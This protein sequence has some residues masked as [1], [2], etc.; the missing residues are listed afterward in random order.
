MPVS[1]LGP[2]VSPRTTQNLDTPARGEPGAAV[3]KTSPLIQIHGPEPKPDYDPGLAAKFKDHVHRALSSGSET[4]LSLIL[5]GELGRGINTEFLN[6][7]SELA[8]TGQLEQ[9]QTLCA[10]FISQALRANLTCSKLI[11]RAF[12]KG[13]ASPGDYEQQIRVM[14]L[15]KANSSKIAAD[16]I[17][18][19][20]KA[21]EYFDTE[22]ADRIK[23]SLFNNMVL[24]NS[25]VNLYIGSVKG[26]YDVESLE[27]LIP[28]TSFLNS[29]LF[30]GDLAYSKTEAPRDSSW[31]DNQQ[32]PYRLASIKA[33]HEYLQTAYDAVVINDGGVLTSGRTVN[34]FNFKNLR[35]G[36][37]L[38]SLVDRLLEFKMAEL[39]SKTSDCREH[40]LSNN[41]LGE[42]YAY[43]DAVSQLLKDLWVNHESPRKT[44]EIDKTLTG[45]EEWADL[46]L[47]AEENSLADAVKDMYSRGLSIKDRLGLYGQST[48]I[49]SLGTDI[50]LL[51]KAML[52]IMLVAALTEETKRSDRQIK[53]RAE[54]YYQKLSPKLQDFYKSC[55]SYYA[56]V[57]E[58]RFK[59]ASMF[60]VI[61][62]ISDQLRSVDLGWSRGSFYREQ[63]ISRDITTQVF[64]DMCDATNVGSLYSVIKGMRHF[65]S[66]GE[67]IKQAF[68]NDNPEAN[69][70][71]F[72]MFFDALET[73]SVMPS[74][75]SIAKVDNSVEDR[76][77]REANEKINSFISEPG[78]LGT[79][80]PPILKLLYD[81]LDVDDSRALQINRRTC[82]LAIFTYY[83]LIKYL[84]DKSDNIYDLQHRASLVKAFLNP[85]VNTAIK[86]LAPDLFHDIQDKL[87]NL[88]GFERASALMNEIRS[89]IINPQKSFKRE[90]LL[91]IYANLQRSFEV[92]R[93]ENITRDY[94]HIDLQTVIPK[95]A[96]Q[97]P[98]SVFKF[99][100][101]IESKSE[102]E[103]Y[104]EALAAT[105]LQYAKQQLTKLKI[106]SDQ[107]LIISD[108]HKSDLI[109]TAEFFRNLKILDELSSKHLLNPNL[110]QE[111]AE[112][113][114]S[115]LRLQ[116]NLISSGRPEGYRERELHLFKYS[117]VQP[118]VRAAYGRPGINFR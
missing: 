108:E 41:D 111:I 28:D 45:R 67:S 70:Q 107:K 25:L 2:Q 49:G 106:S 78:V 87:F 63:G 113:K 60:K 99:I 100:Q 81:T 58:S 22:T 91:E 62:L 75:L 48:I 6:S 9:A 109:F 59:A 89:Q 102:R 33:L 21:Y 27:T 47:E 39:N 5:I 32:V 16:S 110:S 10:N 80:A 30:S 35:S 4:D 12:Q 86:S 8:K 103:T 23:S 34:V 74:Q 7:M 97:A 15:L 92:M 72:T 46:G 65:A 66:L 18:T 57:P 112:L 83:I 115:V 17:Q 19:L 3:G 116:P 68:V 117:V 71:L 93:F 88:D 77:A 54:D 13:K 95:I 85:K 82:R 114:N 43:E 53:L 98:T 38:S 40:Q 36:Q 51:D 118:L 37:L 20:L 61:G 76:E 79:F 52:E 84:P 96:T 29:S 73:N 26:I 104:A 1:E 11:S 55:Q 31:L 44:Q 101:R 69:L 42:I 14:K 50:K 94:K 56:S 64:A 24:R 90:D 105:L